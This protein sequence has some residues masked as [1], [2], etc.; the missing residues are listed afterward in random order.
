MIKELLNYYMSTVSLRWDHELF[1]KVI[2]VIQS[3]I[4]LLNDGKQISQSIL[5]PVID[6]SKNFT[7]VYHH[8]KEKNIIL[9]IIASWNTPKYCINY[10]DVNESWTFMRNYKVNGK[11]C[12][13]IHW[14]K[15]FY[16]FN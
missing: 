14:F 7:R 10:N 11:F 2:Q 12:K 5:Y 9:F 16:K 6:F 4:L 3:I 13:R 1:E 8:T 15:K